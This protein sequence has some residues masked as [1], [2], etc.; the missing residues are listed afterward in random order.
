MSV[1]GHAPSLLD[2]RADPGE[3]PPLGR[4]SPGDSPEPEG[5]E[6]LSPLL[7]RQAG[8]ATGLRTALEGVEPEVVVAHP[9]GPLA[10][11][12]GRDAHAA[13]DLGLSQLARQEETT[14]LEAAFLLLLDG[15]L[16]RLPHAAA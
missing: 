1:V 14:G 9:P 2:R 8:R 3:R 11:G 13:S 16:A 12:P 7:G 5:L 15:P 10:H 4:E 6:D